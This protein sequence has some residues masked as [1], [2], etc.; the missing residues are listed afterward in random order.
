MD[1]EIS[2]YLVACNKSGEWV[3]LQNNKFVLFGAGIAIFELSRMFL[4][5]EISE[6]IDNDK[7][8]WGKEIQVLGKCMNIKSPQ[9]LKEISI[10]EYSIVITSKKYEN[11][12]IKSIG[13]YVDVNQI[14][15]FRYS[16]I[17]RCY[18]KITDLL[19]LDPI[20]K[21]LLLTFN[22]SLETYQIIDDFLC[23]TEKLGIEADCFRVI[24]SGSR[25]VIHF[26]NHKKISSSYVYFVPGRHSTSKKMCINRDKEDYVKLRWH[27]IRSLGIDNDITIYSDKY[28]IMVQKFLKQNSYMDKEKTIKIVFSK[29]KSLHESEIK[30]DIENDMTA[31]YCLD[32]LNEIKKIKQEYY[33]LINV[34]EK[35]I[36]D[37]ILKLGNYSQK[38]LCH[39]DLT[40]D[41]VIFFE[42]TAYIID[43]EYM[44]MA[45]PMYDVC[46]YLCTMLIKDANNY[47]TESFLDQLYHELFRTLNYY[48]LRE[49]S[50]TEY[51]HAK[52]VLSICYQ[53]EILM[54]VIC[55][56]ITDFKCIFPALFYNIECAKGNM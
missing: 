52:M 27:T 21:Y 47:L 31:F 2:G 54:D 4:P 12:M 40:V 51:S 18:K 22:L 6:I 45:D 14:N 5:E 15:I 36:A 17:S 39:C 23:I 9:I 8:K 37:I 55:G 16:D 1:N 50:E 49:A 13:K 41:N 24:P 44:G 10:R 26:W 7:N 33:E 20:A 28:G 19:F 48:Y 30:L 53:R 46:E 32:M 56:E 35:S 25:L 38:K 11:E 43:W 42:D 3:R 29:I 34:L